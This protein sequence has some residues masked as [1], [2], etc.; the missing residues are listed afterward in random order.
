VE[1]AGSLSQKVHLLISVGW[2]ASHLHAR[3]VPASSPNG[4]LGSVL[5]KTQ[6]LKERFRE[7]LYPLLYPLDI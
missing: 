6:T 2:W 7:P 4:A 5:V 3:S 1:T